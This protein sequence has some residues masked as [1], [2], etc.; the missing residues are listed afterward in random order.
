MARA[1]LPHAILLS[2]PAGA[3]KSTLAEDI[4]AF[5]LCAAADGE[6]PCG[7]C[8]ACRLVRDGRHPDVHLLAP[9][10]PGGQ[11]R[12]DAVRSLGADLALH[13]VEGNARLAI[14]ERA[15]RM[16]EDA[17]HVLLKTLEEP[18]QGVTILLVADD[19][20]RLLPTVRSRVARVRLGRA[21]VR[22]I[23]ALLS[24]LG[25]AEPPDGARIA[26]AADGLPGRAIAYAG[27]PAALAERAEMGRLIL[28]M[29]SMPR[30][31]R[32]GLASDLLA[33]ASA[34][35]RAL[36]GGGSSPSVPREPADGS[37]E[38]AASTKVPPTERRRALAWLIALWEDVARDLAAAILGDPRRVRETALL[39]DLTEA[40]PRVGMGEVLAFLER[41]T[42]T[43][44]RLEANVSP[45]LALDGLVLAWPRLADGV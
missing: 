29:L 39:D 38:P 3:G 22:D 14:V 6:R 17:Q 26:R 42:V 18:P 32:L 21:P 35:A 30:A 11:V 34:A 44:R 28:D 36:E 1:G 9:D 37:G 45:E 12:V 16:N 43:S 7:A 23:E 27:A 24:E 41:L 5:A 10:G 8:R 4:A 40:A 2:G 20:D 13:G 15:D 31:R 25:L 19:E 33:S